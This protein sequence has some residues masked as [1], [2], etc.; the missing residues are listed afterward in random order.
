M[1]WFSSSS[2]NGSYKVW[3]SNTNRTEIAGT[4]ITSQ[5]LSNRFNSLG[6]RGTA[7]NPAGLSAF[8][9]YVNSQPDPASTYTAYKATASGQDMMWGVYNPKANCSL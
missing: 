9:S 6:G 7:T 3:G 8:M 5:A 2:Y 1:E 4:V